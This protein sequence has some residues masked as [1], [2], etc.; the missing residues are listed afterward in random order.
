MKRRKL[1]ALT[2]QVRAARGGVIAD[3]RVTM[4]VSFANGRKDRNRSVCP[5]TDTE[6]DFG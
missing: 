6:R 4:C 1:K 5:V 3:H 2:L